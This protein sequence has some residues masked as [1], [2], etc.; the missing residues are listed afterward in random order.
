M[1]ISINFQNLD[2]PTIPEDC[3]SCSLHKNRIQYQHPKHPS[4]R[5]RQERTS[6]DSAEIIPPRQQNGFSEELTTYHKSPVSI[7]AGYTPH[8]QNNLDFNPYFSSLDA[9]ANIYENGILKP[10]QNLNLS[11]E[12][13]VKG[14]DKTLTLSDDK[15]AKKSRPK[16]I[17]SKFLSFIVYSVCL[18]SVVTLCF[19]SPIITFL[20]LHHHHY[21]YFPQTN[22]A[23]SN[24]SSQ[25]HSHSH[26][27]QFE[28]LENKQIPGE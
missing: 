15:N 9:T 8:H 28:T 22:C 16:S 5:H 10:D 2:L 11:H 23:Q 4:S 19:A 12:K 26:D 13:R 21:K 14:K 25:H 6:F 7:E 24:E 1:N 27:V 3:I 17:Y 18:M 20:L